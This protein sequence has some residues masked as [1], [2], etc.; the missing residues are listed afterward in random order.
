[1]SDPIFTPEMHEEAKQIME[2][3]G[4][5]PPTEKAIKEAREKFFQGVGDES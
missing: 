2:K 4:L 1:M 5:T 3:A